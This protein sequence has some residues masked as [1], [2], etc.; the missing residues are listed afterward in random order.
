MVIINIITNLLLF[1]VLFIIL[2][3]LPGMAITKKLVK[4]ANSLE[5]IILSAAIGI[6]LVSLLSF[7]TAMI[8]D[9]YLTRLVVFTAAALLFIPFSRK[10]I[11]PMK[12]DKVGRVAIVTGIALLIL[13]TVL[14]DKSMFDFHC[15]NQDARNIVFG[16]DMEDDEFSGE[17]KNHGL[18]LKINDVRYGGLA[19]V[20]TLASA[21]GWFG[22]RLSY[23]LM[24]V[25]IS[26]L[27]YVIAQNIFKRTA[28][29]FA[30]MF[31]VLLPPLFNL[32][33]LDENLIA[34]MVSLLLIFLFL[35]RADY[36]LIGAIFGLLVGIRHIGILWII[37]IL[38]WIFL[39]SSKEERAKKTSKFVVWSTIAAIPWM[40]HHY[41][42]FG[43][44]LGHESIYQF[45]SFPHQFLWW[46]FNFNGLLNYPFYEQIVRTPYNAFPTFIL[47]T[48]TLIREMGIV[49]ASIGLIGY[50]Y[51]FNKKRKLAL[52][53]GLWF[54]P[55]LLLL[56][57]QENW[58]QPNKMKFIVTIFA[59]VMICWIAGFDWIFSDYK[60]RMKWLLLI[61]F[62]IL[63]GAFMGLIQIPEFAA[64]ERIYTEYPSLVKE[65]QEVYSF[66][67]SRFR[68][69][70]ILPSFNDVGYGMDDFT[71]AIMNPEEK[72]PPYKTEK[73]VGIGNKQV[74]IALSEPL[75]Y[76]TSFISKSHKE[77]IH[78]QPDSAYIVNDIHLDW[79]DYPTNVLVAMNSFN[80]IIVYVGYDESSYF[81]I[82]PLSIAHMEYRNP[83]QEEVRIEGLNLNLQI[84]ENARIIFIIRLAKDEQIYYFR[85][86]EQDGDRFIIH[87]SMKMYNN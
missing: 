43:M 75:I 24:M 13:F 29:A 51:I 48:A 44:I 67:K 22:F 47:F 12:I 14:Y 41:F 9:I 81:A 28:I 32:R 49:L 1:I 73:I 87:D 86:V 10:I 38:F 40:I 56:S 27:C 50:V 26:L 30:S 36:G 18:L 80:D 62:M 3:F 31:L 20:S 35:K 19:I 15:I 85:S 61:L 46:K 25:L 74:S 66:E 58:I 45:G 63:C 23:A 64:D 59:P 68:G 42:A 72:F 83:P 77:G 11:G 16:I 60:N 57:V 5:I 33:V 69:V 53:L 79:F 76:S 34:L 52:F 78:M 37:P 8:A 84:P 82:G 71:Y 4:K 2:F 39:S 54:I 21:F 17:H 65:T 55:I 7:T 70:H 6:C